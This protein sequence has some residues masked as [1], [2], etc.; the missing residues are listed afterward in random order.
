[1]R[2][3][4]FVLLALALGTGCDSAEGVGVE[5]TYRATS[6]TFTKGGVVTDL[7]AEGGALELV[8]GPL[9]GTLAPFD[10]RFSPPG[11]P[12]PV[13]FGGT[14]DVST[15][16]HVGRAPA[17]DQVVLFTTS[18]NVFL[19]GEGLGLRGDRLLGRV[20]DDES[21]GVYSLTLQR[22]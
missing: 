12:V 20:P 7:L 11:F 1:M 13:S 3:H 5:G 21:G 19:A 10:G 17:Y 2:T 18:D 22:D 6:L 8:L 14:Y 4:L 16:G 15:R 9:N